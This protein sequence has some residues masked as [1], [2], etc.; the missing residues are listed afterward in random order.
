MWD[1]DQVNRVKQ[2]ISNLPVLHGAV[3]IDG[4]VA[5]GKSSIVSATASYS[6]TCPHDTI[7]ALEPVHKWLPELTTFLQYQVDPAC[8]HSLKHK[9]MLCNALEH[10]CFSSNHHALR[11]E[12]ALAAY[13]IPLP[14]VT[15]IERHRALGVL[16]FAFREAI[17]QPP[18]LSKQ[19]FMSL[20]TLIEKQSALP[21]NFIHIN[22][23]QHNALHALSQER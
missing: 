21:A 4:C 23:P 12:R 7:F 2:V 15:I 5:A 17:S 11:D 19:D 6:H 13:G 8:A 22:T 16:V 14:C 3:S 10:K 20:C 1:P 18:L 9:Q